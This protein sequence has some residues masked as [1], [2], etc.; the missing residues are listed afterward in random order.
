MDNSGDEEHE[1]GV[2]DEE[3]DEDEM[4][5][6]GFGEEDDEDDQGPPETEIEIQE[7]SFNDMQVEFKI[8]LA[9]DDDEFIRWMSTIHVH[10]THNGEII[11]RAFGR[12]IKRDLIRPT[13]WRDMEEPSEE[14]AA[15][16]FGVFDRYGRLKK[17]FKDHP[18]R[19]GT[20]AWGS[21]LDLG[22]IF[23]AED[24]FINKEWRRR[25]IGRRVAHHLLEKA[26]KGGR[27]LKFSLVVPGRLYRDIESDLKGKTQLE[28]RVIQ[29]GAADVSSAFWRSLGFRRI[30]A[31]ACLGFAEDA[32]HATH[33][34]LAKNDFEPA[35]EDPELDEAP[36]HESVADRNVEPAKNSWR[37][38]LLKDRLPLHHA[39]LTLSDIEC[40][41]F[42]TT[43]KNS[44]KPND[45]WIKVDRSRM[46]V[47]HIAAGEVDPQSVHWLLDNSEYGETLLAAR[48][49]NGNTPLEHLESRLDTMRT[50]RERGRLTVDI[51]DN[52]TGLFAET[53][54]CLAALWGM[55]EPTPIERARL[56]FGCTC[57]SCIDGF[58][59]P[60]MKFALLC[61]A[62][63]TNDML[64]VDTTDGEMWCMMHDYLFDYVAPHIQRN[65]TINASYRKGFANVL[66]HVAVTLRSNNSP[67]I[68][69]ILGGIEHANE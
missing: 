26:R 19:Q 53:I 48:D 35:I 5:E 2:T 56:K 42:F 61:Q 40:V 66:Y 32:S 4:Y 60:R 44:D 36:E 69:N 51:S 57:G 22:A 52:F 37:L 39:V 12:Y 18:I 67:T 45:E 33:R 24:I 21:E 13:F 49:V 63:M 58:L 47:L 9:E 20:G 31:S 23:L 55:K 3:D 8:F 7:E 16:A 50:R 29:F 25:G 30:G 11:G 17:E 10:C 43:F 28:Q 15:V 41:E 6:S 68:A 1:A 34:I 59:S 46:N 54:D 65:F 14:L 27:M 64:D 62:E 38:A